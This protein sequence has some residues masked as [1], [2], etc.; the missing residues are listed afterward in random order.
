MRGLVC[1]LATALT[2]GV[3]QV[4]AVPV[5][6]G[7]A[8]TAAALPSGQ[9]GALGVRTAAA[10]AGPRDTGTGSVSAH[11]HEAQRGRLPVS[12]SA[13]ENMHAAVDWQYMTQI[14]CAGAWHSPCSTTGL[15]SIDCLLR[16]SSQLACILLHN[17]TSRAE[18]ARSQLN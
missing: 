6:T 14:E 8:V 15:L 1:V 3:P 7:T 9:L 11:E 5:P 17:Q 2:L 12:A 4:V 18:S 13:S 16:S 10:A